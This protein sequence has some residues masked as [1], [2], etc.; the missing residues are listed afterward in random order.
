MAKPTATKSLLLKI[1]KEKGLPALTKLPDIKITSEILKR[2]VEYCAIKLFPQFNEPDFIIT[3]AVASKIDS[4][5]KAITDKL[6]KREIT[7]ASIGYEGTELLNNSVAKAP[8]V[9]RKAKEVV[10]ENPIKRGRKPKSS[11]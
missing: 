11:E 9:S 3:D 10:T 5:V 8:R 1:R 6:K 4:E 7:L 2:A